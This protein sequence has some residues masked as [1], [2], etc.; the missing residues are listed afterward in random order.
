MKNGLRLDLS[1][2][3][4]SLAS[5]NGEVL[6]FPIQHNLRNSELEAMPA[7]AHQKARRAGKQ[8]SVIG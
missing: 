3:L 7:E 4:L 6:D 8:Q 1:I 2:C 5:L